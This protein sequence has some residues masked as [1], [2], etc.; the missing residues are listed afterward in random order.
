MSKTYNLIITEKQAQA[1][2]CAVDLLQRIQ[3]G[4]WKE[5]KDH[6]PLKKPIEYEN[7]HGDMQVIS[8]ILS[9]HMV[10]NVDGGFSSLGLG[11]PSLPESNGIL[12]DL[13]QVIRRKLSIEQAVED[14]VIQNENVSQNEMPINMNF[15][16]PIKWGSEELA[17]MERLGVVNVKDIMKLIKEL[18]ND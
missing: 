17:T 6:L 14:G 8:T 2:L 12:Y 16:V 7:L 13:Y 5:I 10:N 3:L 1:I 18:E 11:H 15:D 4:Q 9:W